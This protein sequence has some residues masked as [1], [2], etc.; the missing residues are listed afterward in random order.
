VSES[1]ECKQEVTARPKGESNDPSKT[2]DKNY[3]DNGA[4]LSYRPKRVPTFL[5]G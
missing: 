1:S 5:L 2:W 4:L 3:M